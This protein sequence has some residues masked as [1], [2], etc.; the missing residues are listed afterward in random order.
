MGVS[1]ETS[2]AA[3]L[4]RP[5]PGDVGEAGWLG[6]ARETW[7]S[8]SVTSRCAVAALLSQ[9]TSPPDTYLHCA[10]QSRS[11]LC[12]AREPGVS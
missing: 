3:I 2:L 12:A 1:C 4:K 11:R 6:A 9:L 10:P 7:Q 8:S 5:E